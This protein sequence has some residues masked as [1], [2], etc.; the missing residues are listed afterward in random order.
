[1]RTV[2][3]L[4]LWGLIELRRKWK[5]REMEI[6]LGPEPSRRGRRQQVMGEWQKRGHGGVVF[7]LDPPT[8]K[9]WASES[10]LPGRLLVSRPA[11]SG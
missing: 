5:G 2:L 3:H 1:M 6:I 11:C 7:I 10:H 8:P 9:I 4:D